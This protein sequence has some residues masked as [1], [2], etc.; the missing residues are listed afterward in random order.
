MNS[1]YIFA[2]ICFAGCL[3]T[4][5][6]ETSKAAPE[7]VALD[8]ICDHQKHSLVSVEGYLF[9]GSMSCEGTKRRRSSKAKM[10]SCTMSLYSAPNRSGHSIKV[11]IETIGW[12]KKNGMEQP[13][14]DQLPV[15]YD[16]E[17]NP[18]KFTQKLRIS[19]KLDN[20]E[21][22]IMGGIKSIEQL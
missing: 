15:I 11:R 19:G 13:V 17:A 6:E 3:V 9:P 14:G 2:I 10:N 18:I 7:I 1:K 22:C 4:A 12:S 16:H 8:K 20:S 21:N 5:C